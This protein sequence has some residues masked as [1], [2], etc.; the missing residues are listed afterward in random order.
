MH[1]TF[2]KG[3]DPGASG[4]LI[5]RGEEDGTHKRHTEDFEDNETT[6]D[7]TVMMIFVRNHTMSNTK[8]KHEC[9]K[10]P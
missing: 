8:S 10:E 4:C 1:R 7:D 3:Q 5:T 6:L 2:Q 9:T